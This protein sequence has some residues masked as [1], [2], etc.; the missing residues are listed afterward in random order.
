MTRS[1]NRR[2]LRGAAQPGSLPFLCAMDPFALRHTVREL[3]ESTVQ[4][5]GFDLVAIEWIPSATGGTV[6]LSIDTLPGADS[7]GESGDSPESSE[8]AGVTAGAC[9]RV[10]RAVEPLLDAADPI[11]SRYTL[12][13]SSPGIDRPVQRRS[14]F[15]RFIGYTAKLRLEP[16]PPR[17]RY[18][19]TL[20]GLRNDDVLVLVDGQ[21]HALHL[22]TIERAHLVLSLEEYE[23]LG[24]ALPA[25]RPQ[26]DSDDHQ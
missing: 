5:L 7:A 8:P 15:E 14:D 17:R 6:R 21:E 12:E 19:G 9:A 16:G 10:S 24:Q 1:L 26:E 13:V 25:T 22:D 18:T 3:V 11:A 2:P 23:A 20:H 4:R